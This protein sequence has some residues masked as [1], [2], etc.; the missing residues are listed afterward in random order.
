MV[1]YRHSQVAGGTFFFTVNLHYSVKRGHVAR[2]IDWPHSTLHRYI[3][4][5]LLAADWACAS[6]QGTFGE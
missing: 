1:Q 4:H 5:G 6:P 3:K 2:P